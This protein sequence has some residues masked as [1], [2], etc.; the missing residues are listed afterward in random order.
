MKLLRELFAYRTMLTTMI[1]KELVTRYK[2]SVLGF[3]W[4]FIN[5]LLQLL[6]YSVVFSTI[7]RVDVPQYPIYLFVAFIPWFFLSTSVISG[8]NCILSSSNLVQKIYFP[9]L[10]IPISTVTAGFVNMALSMVVVLLAVLVSGIGLSVWAWLLPVVMALQYLLVLGL[11]MIFS[12]V[13][14]YF[15][16]LSHILE[17]VVMAWFYATPIVYPPDMVPQSLR[18]LLRY[19]PMTGI[20]SA[21][22]SILYEKR[23]PDAS[24]LLIAL[25]LG[26]GVCVIGAA[27]F[28][29]LQRSFAEEL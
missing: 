26:L 8:A 27:V 24:T 5:P 12:A 28:E 16:D 15:R 6:V 13:N 18:W 9:R 20:V 1:R 14:V 10:V 4:T 2:G 3:L 25:A 22:R 21:Y 17:I 11:V 23:M 29:K 7:L 19:N